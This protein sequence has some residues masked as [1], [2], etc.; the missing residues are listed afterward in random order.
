MSNATGASASNDRSAEHQDRDQPELG[1]TPITSGALACSEGGFVRFANDTD[2][3]PVSPAKLMQAGDPATPVN[4]PAT[5]TNVGRVNDVIA[6]SP[7][8]R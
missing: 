4:A 6:L 5:E 8:G 3:R 7:D 2:N 1:C